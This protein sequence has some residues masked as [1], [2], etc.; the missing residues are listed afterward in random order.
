MTQERYFL[1]IVLILFMLFP[2]TT[3]ADVEYSYEL[4]HLNRR[5]RDF[6]IHENMEKRFDEERK[7]GGALEKLSR[8]KSE[9]EYEKARI[10]QVKKRKSQ[11]QVDWK[12]LELE[13]LKQQQKIALKQDKVRKKYVKKQKQLLKIKEQAKKIPESVEVGLD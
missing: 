4:K 7:R 9:K 10:E 6:F 5:Y 8:K 11:Q 3:P 12:K 13:Y 2:L 1:S